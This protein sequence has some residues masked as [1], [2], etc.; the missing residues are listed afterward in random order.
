M[1]LLL[2]TL[3]LLIAASAASQPLPRDVLSDS[4]RQVLQIQ[5]RE[6]ALTDQRVRYMSKFGT[7]SPCS[8]DSLRLLLQDLPIEEN[9]ARSRALQAEANARITPAE[10]AVLLEMEH[11]ADDRILRRLRE[12]MAT[13]GW[14]S[15]E[16]TGADASPEV[17]LLH[18]PHKMNEMRADLL[19]EVRAGRLDPK[20]FAMAMD[21]ARIVGG[22]RQLYGSGDE[23]DPQTQ[24]MQPPRID[25]IEA[26]NAA[27]REIGL[28]PLEDYRLVD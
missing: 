1:H 10:K 26:T 21:K 8:A 25:S 4:V 24:S 7:F 15:D 17:F 9:I 28:P 11:E 6:M 2:V 13:Y 22:D 20:H 16:R 23:Y 14:P 5:L 27:R 12:I 18:A 3:L 19:N